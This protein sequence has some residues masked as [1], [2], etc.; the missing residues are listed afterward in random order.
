MISL[1]PAPLT[2]QL[3]P[4][5]IPDV[6]LTSRCSYLRWGGGTLKGHECHT[7]ILLKRD[8]C[9]PVPLSKEASTRRGNSEVETDERGRGKK[10]MSGEPV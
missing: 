2:P 3:L 5:R 6:E 9:E 8:N 7:Q 4:P 10:Q 1:S